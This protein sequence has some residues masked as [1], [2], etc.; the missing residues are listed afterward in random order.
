MQ[1]EGK[2]RR[3]I[4]LYEKGVLVL[5]KTLPEPTPL[6]LQRYYTE[7]LGRVSNTAVA[8]EQRNK[9]AV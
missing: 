5:L 3:T 9:V 8:N 2:S 7:R 1:Q 6:S 4:A